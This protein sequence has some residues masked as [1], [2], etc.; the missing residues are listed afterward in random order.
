MDPVVR[1]SVPSK[2]FSAVAPLL[3]GWDNDAFSKLPL[4]GEEPGTIAAAIANPD[5]CTVAH[6]GRSIA[7]PIGTVASMK[8]ETH[9]A[10]LVLE[11]YGG[12]SRKFDLAEALPILAGLKQFPKK[13]GKLLPG[14]FRNIYVGMSRPT[15]FLCLACNAARVDKATLDALMAAGWEVRQL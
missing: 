6:S 2:I 11:S 7:I 1:A 8:G 12:T 9:L 14:Q 10:T 3:A 5:A 4:F 13:P 15:S